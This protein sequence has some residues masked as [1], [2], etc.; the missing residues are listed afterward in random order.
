MCLPYLF[1]NIFL[2]FSFN[3]FYADFSLLFPSTFFLRFSTWFPS[4]VDWK[5]VR[6]RT[7]PSVCVN[8]LF[9][10]SPE[11][12]MSALEFCLSK[13]CC[14]LLNFIKCF[15]IPSQL[16][17]DINKCLYFALIEVPLCHMSNQLWVRK[18]GTQ[19]QLVVKM[20]SVFAFQVKLCVWSVLVLLHPGTKFCL[21]EAEDDHDLPIPSLYLWSVGTADVCYQVHLIS[22]TQEFC[23][24]WYLEKTPSWNPL[25]Q[26]SFQGLI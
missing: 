24:M 3:L 18:E 16:P 22:V 10:S 1:E 23:A 6:I 7:Y 20:T 15:F 26:T 2:V 12:P 8:H 21:F 25:D 13:G 5:P 11:K 4:A 17:K 14:V 9:G 19:S